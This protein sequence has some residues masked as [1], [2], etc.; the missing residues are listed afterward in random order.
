MLVWGVETDELVSLQLTRRFPSYESWTKVDSH[1]HDLLLTNAMAAI[2]SLSSSPVP[3]LPP[4]PHQF[5]ARRTATLAA[6][7]TPAAVGTSDHRLSMPPMPAPIAKAPRTGSSN[8]RRHRK[9][10]FQMQPS[11]ARCEVLSDF[12]CLHL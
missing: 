8:G 7:G 1:Q 12:C 9:K 11:R 6:P 10:E 3:Q 2:E 5:D 4:R